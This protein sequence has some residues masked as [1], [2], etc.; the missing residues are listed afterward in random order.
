[1][2]PSPRLL[3]GELSFERL[4]P[5]TKN[6][7]V[8]SDLSRTIIYLLPMKYFFS[9]LFLSLTCLLPLAAQPLSGASNEEKLMAAAER[10][11]L[12]SI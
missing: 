5:Y 7:V 8:P 2:A 9:V 11:R 1:V 3:L 10:D 4:P 12:R 6:T